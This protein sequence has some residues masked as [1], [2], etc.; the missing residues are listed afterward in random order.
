MAKIRKEWWIPKL[1]S[2]V[3]KIVNTC[4]VCKVFKTKPYRATAR[5]DKPQFRVEAS[6]PFDT[7]GVN[8]AVPIALK[9][10]K[11]QGKCYILLFTCAMPRAVQVEFTKTQTAEEFQGKLKLARR[12]SSKIMVSDNAS[13]F[14]STATWM[15]NSRKSER[16]QDYLTRQD[17]L[18][19]QLIQIPLLGRHV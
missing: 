14:K 4:N 3:K 9:L 11:E 2:K 15:K 8:F 10:T 17:K 12:T 13:V 6:R 19:I 7:T 5:A 1:R 16:L 18:A